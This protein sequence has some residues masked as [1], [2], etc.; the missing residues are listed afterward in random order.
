MRMTKL[1]GEATGREPVAHRVR[2]AKT[3]E[4]QPRDEPWTGPREV[5]YPKVAPGCLGPIALEPV[6]LSNAKGS[7]GLRDP[8]PL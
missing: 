2:R 8:G 5:P 4:K 1:P 3:D 7:L 6:Q